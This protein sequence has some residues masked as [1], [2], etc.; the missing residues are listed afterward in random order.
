MMLRLIL[1]TTLASVLTYFL[2]I[3]LGLG[4][5]IASSLVGL[6]S[7]KVFPKL[8]AAIYAASFASMS[9]KEVLPNISVSGI[10]GLITGLLYLFTQK[11]FLGIGGKLGAIA[12]FSVL[13]VSRFSSAIYFSQTLSFFEGSFL[14]LGSCLGAV[15]TYYISTRFKQ[16]AVFSSSIVVLAAGLI[17]NIFLRFNNNL[18]AAITCGSYAGMSSKEVIGNYRRMCLVG[19]LSG[20]ILFLSWPLFSGIGGKLGLVAFLAVFLSKPH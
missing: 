7:A 18:V 3:N 9:S 10:A 15:L 12:F 6:T 13:I 17:L 19:L 14:I 4:P 1:S 2:S 5:F 16:E 8:A 20:I 11:V